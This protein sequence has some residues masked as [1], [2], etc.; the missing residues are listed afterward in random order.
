MMH[1]NELVRAEE[2]SPIASAVSRTHVSTVERTLDFIDKEKR[3]VARDLIPHIRAIVQLTR[4]P[5]GSLFV[6]KRA[7][8]F[9]QKWVI[10]HGHSSIKEETQLF[11]FMEHISDCALDAL[12]GHP[13]SRPQVKSTRFPI[14][15]FLGFPIQKNSWSTSGS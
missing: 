6:S 12:L 7:A 5:D 4:S 10:G 3:A 13:L 2:L 9:N 8:D 11:G 1:Y 14:L 15:T